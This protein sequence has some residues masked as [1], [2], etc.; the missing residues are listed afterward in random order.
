MRR[1]ELL[2]LHTVTAY[3]Y[4]DRTIRCLHARLDPM[5]RRTIPQE[6]FITTQQEGGL[7]SAQEIL[8]IGAAEL[9]ARDSGIE[10]P[11]PF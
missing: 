7:W 11:L 1:K 8:F 10:Y 2:E 4:S 9:L 3:L 5:T 6:L